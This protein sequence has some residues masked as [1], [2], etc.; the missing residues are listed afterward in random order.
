[1]PEVMHYGSILSFKSALD[2]YAT[3]SASKA[4]TLLNLVAIEG[5]Y[6]HAAGRPWWKFW[7]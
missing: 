6:T 3:T 7:R 2:V 1:M 5:Y 4:I